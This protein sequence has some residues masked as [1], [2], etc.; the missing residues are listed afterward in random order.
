MTRKPLT[1]KEVKAGAWRQSGLY[2]AQPG[3]NGAVVANT[4]AV[5]AAG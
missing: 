2:A 1:A 3:G 4:S 5:A